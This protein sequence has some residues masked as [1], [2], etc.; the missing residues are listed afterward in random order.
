MCGNELIGQALN[1]GDI[2]SVLND[3]IE[4]P[5]E[6]RIVAAI[7]QLQALGA[8]D[9]NQHLTSLGRILLQLPTDAATGKLVLY[10]SFFRCLE[11]A[12]TL[13]A[14][15]ATRDPFLAPLASRDAARAAR[16]AWSP[17][18]FRSDLLTIVAAYRHWQELD[19]GGRYREAQEFCFQNF[20]SRPTMLQIKQ[21][22]NQIL[23]S[24]DKAGVLE[25]SSGREGVDTANVWRSYH[26]RAGL[27]G[28]VPDHLN[29]NAASLPLLAALLAM[30]HSPNFAVNLGEHL[31]RTR[32]D[33]NVTIAMSSVNSPKRVTASQGNNHSISAEVFQS[34]ERRLYAFVEKANTIGVGMSETAVLNAPKSLRGTTRID[35][36]TYLLFGAA[37]LQL[38]EFPFRGMICDEWLPIKGHHV[39]LGDLA[40]LRELMDGCILRVFEGLAKM[41][42][43]SRHERERHRLGTRAG[44]EPADDDDKDG[45]R[46]E[47]EAEDGEVL[48]EEE[49]GDAQKR[50]GGPLTKDEIKEFELLT[51]DVVRVL[52]CYALE[53]QGTER[54][55]Q[56][57]PTGPGGGHF[58]SRPNSR[59]FN[60]DFSRSGPS[61]RSGPDLF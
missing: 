8:L 41:L 49:G 4:P 52:D 54:S 14:V 34:F 56:T 3:T 50:A 13:A 24:L 58:N 7:E 36:M 5:E 2:T 12:L 11:P 44:A 38:G 15:Q 33:K 18:A 48:D 60:F 39:H 51:M 32:H 19:S 42:G 20:L 55:G 26:R 59:A 30:T 6:A 9:D 35:P 31:L 45:L 10:G 37:K 61:H 43:M 1:F 23:D 40:R 27:N 16:D 21:H 28:R 29:E 25:I 57:T 47:R 17:R 22:R 46:G 53:R